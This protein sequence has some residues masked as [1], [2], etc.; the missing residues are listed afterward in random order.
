MVGRSKRAAHQQE[1]GVLKHSHAHV[2]RVRLLQ[3]LCFPLQQQPQSNTVGIPT[4]NFQ[5]PG[6]ALGACR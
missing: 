5:Q 6:P 1:A 4:S 3:G 2:T